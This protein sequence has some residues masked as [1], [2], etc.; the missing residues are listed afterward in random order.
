MEA[1]RDLGKRL[2]KN[3]SHVWRR[4]W[5]GIPNSGEPNHWDGAAIGTLSKSP[6]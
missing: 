4:R 6:G 1:A 3:W 5:C 2:H